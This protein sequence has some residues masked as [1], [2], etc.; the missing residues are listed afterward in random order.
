MTFSDEIR[1]HHL[2]KRQADTLRVMPL[3]AGYTKNVKI[4]RFA[5]NKHNCACYEICGIT[6]YVTRDQ[7]GLNA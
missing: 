2:P 4:E 3:F 6:K 7:K 1:T 5:V